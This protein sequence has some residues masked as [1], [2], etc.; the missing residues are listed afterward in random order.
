MDPD[1]VITEASIVNIFQNVKM[2]HHVLEVYICSDEEI[3]LGATPNATFFV[4]S[5]YLL[6]FIIMVP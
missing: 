2:P 3:Y 5:L 4:E 1:E 6:F